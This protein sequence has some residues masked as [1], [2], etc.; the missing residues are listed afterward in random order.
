MPSG[1]SLLLREHGELQVTQAKIDRNQSGVILKST[2]SFI[3]KCIQNCAFL[4]TQL[5][6]DISLQT[7][8]IV[9]SLI[10]PEK[11]LL[12]FIYTA[13]VYLSQI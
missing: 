13:F 3:Y 11:A 7:V 6:C 8:F 1:P 5:Y 9:I 4:S 2:S 12:S 10:V